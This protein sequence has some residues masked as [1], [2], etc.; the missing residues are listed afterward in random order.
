MKK[1]QERGFGRDTTPKFV[2]SRDLRFESLEP[3]Y[4]LDGSVVINE[5]M[6]HPE[7]VSGAEAD[8]EWVELYNQMSI[9]MDISG[10]RLEGGVQYTFAEGTVIPGRGYSVL[11]SNPTALAAIGGINIAPGAFAGR[12]S[13]SGEEIILVNRDGR[14]ISI[15]DY[16]DS[17][18]WAT[19]SRRFRL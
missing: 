12:L 7:P 14:Q 16:A 1:R 13:N 4:V 19:G 11:S 2:R 17:A 15:V 8:Y 10:W 3:R 9:N 18:P 6:Y 5:I